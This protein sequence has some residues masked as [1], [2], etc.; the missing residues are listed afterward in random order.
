MKWA[1]YIKYKL[2]AAAVL[3]III[4]VI[5]VGNLSER[6]SFSNLDSSMTS[7]FN[8]RLKPSSYLYEISQNLYEKRLL[9]HATRQPG[10]TAEK[11]REHNSSIASLMRAYETT[12]LTNE[13]RQQWNNFRKHLQDY[14]LL[15]NTWLA[16]AMNASQPT[17]SMVQAF[18][19]T[20]DNLNHLNKIQVG[21]GNNLRKSSHSI[22]SNNL[23][24]SSLE[25]SL[26]VV[27][28]LFTLILLSAT[29]H[30]LFRNTGK[31]A[32]N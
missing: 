21:E 11:I 3:T 2:R 5:L 12:Y 10:E 16:S 17:A 19:L 32:L 28:S 31:E 4:L 1:F 7:I 18:D 24:F 30:R 29:D 14:N 6:K 9:L 23:M 27:L 22:V 8:D 15:E 13:E 26:L 20:L 25:I